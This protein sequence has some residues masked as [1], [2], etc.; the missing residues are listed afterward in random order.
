MQFELKLRD[1]EKLVNS[2]Y[3][4]EIQGY[5]DREEAFKKEKQRLKQEIEDLM[6]QKFILR[7]Q[8]LGSIIL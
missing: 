5:K 6:K 8:G 7:M 4:K 2:H 3:A 1:L